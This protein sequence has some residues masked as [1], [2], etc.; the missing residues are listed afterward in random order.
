MYDVVA[1]QIIHELLVLRKDVSFDIFSIIQY[2]INI[3]SQKF[4]INTI[5]FGTYEGILSVS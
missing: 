3:G 5:R 1:E 4:V 2:S